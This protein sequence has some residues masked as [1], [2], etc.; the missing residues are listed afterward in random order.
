MT[1]SAGGAT[2]ADHYEALARKGRKKK[3]KGPKLP[4]GAVHLWNAFIQL[5]NARGGNGYGPN[6]I[7]YTEIDAFCRLTETALDPWEIEAIRALDDAYLTAANQK[8]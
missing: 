2:V 7:P 8:E 3:P 1:R 5:S 6:P 4:P